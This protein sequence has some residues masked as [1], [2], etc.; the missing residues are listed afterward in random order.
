MKSLKKILLT[1]CTLGVATLLYFA[2][3]AFADTT[4]TT[5]TPT[6]TNI[7]PKGTA[8]G[9][10]TSGYDLKVLLTGTGFASS[11]DVNF[12]SDKVTLVAKSL[13]IISDTSAKA[14]F[15]LTKD[16]PDIVNVTVTVG[17]AKSE[18][19]ALATGTTCI[20]ALPTGAC[21]LRLTVVGTTAT[22]SA[23]QTGTSTTPNILATL[24]YQWMSPKPPD[25]VKNRNVLKLMALGKDAS[26]AKAAA[27]KAA[28]PK[29]GMMDRAVAH[30]SFTTGYTQV[31]TANKVVPTTANGASTP[32]MTLSERTSSGATTPATTTMATQQQAFVAQGK[33]TFGF[34][35]GRDGSG[36]FAELGG[37]ARGSLQYLLSPNQIIQNGG[38]TYVNL[39]ANNPNNATSFYEFT[40][41]FNVG[42]YNH[43][44]KATTANTYD[45]VSHLLVI[46]GGYQNNSGLQQLI[47]GSPQTNTRDR[48]V[49]RFYLTPELPGN[50]KHTTIT[51]G[52]EYS[53]GMNGGPKI[54][55]VFVGTN[56][57]P[58]KLFSS[59][60]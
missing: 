11:M 16:A 17:T 56:L 26:N 13:K 7:T 10:S 43:D 27:A 48:V 9:D 55:Q 33:A 19:Y 54:V 57:N 53:R 21:R 14:T 52:M 5:T 15:H 25:V 3:V 58:A 22:G 47:A 49:G 38:L 45:N 59:T 20:D 60:Q 31:P 18:P 8:S 35:L 29:Q 37:G 6:L 4:A 1:P 32:S 41:H 2:V 46:E 39:S 12:D 42:Q 28:A 34:S 44:Q 24:D 40:G 36:T 51:L 50:S 23:S 30:A